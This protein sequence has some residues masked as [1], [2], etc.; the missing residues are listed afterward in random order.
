MKEANYGSIWMIKYEQIAKYIVLP[1]AKDTCIYGIVEDVNYVHENYLFVVR[2][3]KNYDSYNDIEIA[4]KKK[5]IV[6]HENPLEKRGFYVSCLS[7][8]I[9]EVLA[10]V[11]RNLCEDMC[12]VGV[13]GSNGKSSVVSFLYDM[14]PDQKCMKIGTHFVESGK[15]RYQTHNTTPDKIM[16]M[17]FLVLARKHQVRYVFMEVSSIA[18]A[19]KRIAFVRFDY[20]IYT[21]IA[22]DHLDFHK[23]LLHYRYTK[24]KLCQYVKDDGYV[25][26][27]S[28]EFYYMELSKLG[29]KRLITYGQNASH[30][31]MHD[32]MISQYESTFF[33]NRHYFKSSMLS[34]VNV[35]NISACIA[36]FR[37]EGFSYYH[38]YR[39]ILGLK[40]LEG[41][42]ECVYDKKIRV[43]IDYAHTPQAF[44]ETLQ[45]LTALPHHHL[46]CV[47][48]C[49]GERDQSKRAVIGKY[50]SYFS[51]ICIFTEDNSRK[52]KLDTILLDMTK[53]VSKAPIWI[54]NRKEAIEYAVKKAINGDIILISG[55]GNETFLEKEGKQVPFNDKDIVLGML[56]DKDGN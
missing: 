24:Y 27:C 4:L 15:I 20:I 18:I 17:H 48:G 31:H 1:L 32:L 50:A 11:Y 29:I 26:A 40:G 35:Y 49:G 34:L 46:I 54:R 10:H 8:C 25:I 14:M 6:V 38:I 22:R 30:F 53:K 44:Y 23:T 37:L 42:I 52:E 12:I 16:L 45:F 21:N 19:Q 2:K 5:A 41:R 7:S 9:D 43:Y 56:G 3:G 39:S 36:L 33:V 28:D 55:K 47:V 51:D 13:C